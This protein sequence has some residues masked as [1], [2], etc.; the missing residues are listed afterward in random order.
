MEQQTK[1]KAALS[2]EF[3]S[4]V[5]DKKHY[6]VQQDNI[7]YQSVENIYAAIAQKD[8]DALNL[9]LLNALRPELVKNENQKRKFKKSLMVFI[10]IVLSVQLGVILLLIAVI[11]AHTVLDLPFITK[12]LNNESLKEIFVFLKYY[13]AATIGEFIAM[14]FFIVK[15]VFDKS[16]VDLIS[17][18]VK[19]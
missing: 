6:R 17:H 7:S 3:H 4:F 15:Y 1:E 10:E 2:A 12:D 18:Y 5:N 8:H 16:I 14:L 9:L 13:I 19:K 11:C